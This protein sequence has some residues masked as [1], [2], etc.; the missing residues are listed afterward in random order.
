MVAKLILHPVQ[1][2][3]DSWKV[4]FWKWPSS[5]SLSLYQI[6][7]KIIPGC[8]DKWIL[9][10]K[11]THSNRRS[12]FNSEYP[13]QILKVL[14]NVG[15]SSICSLFVPFSLKCV[16]LGDAAKFLDFLVL[17]TDT[18]A[19]ERDTLYLPLKVC[20]FHYFEHIRLSHLLQTC[21]C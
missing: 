15:L 4:C 3:V 11:I 9:N 17:S 6:F 21:S 8:T 7:S 12:S 5:G 13:S 1:V 16:T 2:V 19:Y 18:A 20:Y 14:Q 10:Y